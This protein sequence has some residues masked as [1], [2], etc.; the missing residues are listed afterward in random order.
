[1][2]DDRLV[3]ARQVWRK[4]AADNGALLAAAVSFYSFFS[5]FPLLLLAVGVV[6][7]AFGSPQHAEAILNR[8]TGKFVVGAQAQSIIHE[9]VH[10]RYAATGVGLVMLLWSGTSAMVV[11]EQAM[12]LAWSTSARRT[13]LARRGIALLTLLVIAVLGLVSFGAAALIRAAS[14]TNAPYMAWMRG[15]TPAL[16][17]PIPALASIGLFVTIYKLLPN[18]RVSWRTALVGGVFA[19]VMWETA[20]HVFAFYIVH[21]PGHNRVYGSLASVI[22]L[23]L[24]LDYSAVIAILGAEFASLWS[25]RREGSS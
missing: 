11:L 6:G 25:R 23:M 19:G 24:W 15:I 2:L 7:Y 18:T 3:L 9:I 8:L 4:F 13:Y 12:N 10:G 5:L 14:S 16:T 21:W 20:K 1:M 17:Y 22:L